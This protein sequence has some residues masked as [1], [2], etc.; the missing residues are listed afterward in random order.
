MN[1]DFLV[2]SDEDVVDQYPRCHMAS[3]G[4]NEL[5][6]LQKLDVIGN[7]PLTR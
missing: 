7:P 2:M 5:I 4:Y 3:L 6:M 1:N